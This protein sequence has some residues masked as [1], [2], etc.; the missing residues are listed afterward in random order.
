DD[1]WLA[2]RGLRTLAVRLAHHQQAALIV[3]KWLEGRREVSRV[4]YPALASCPGH[5]IWRRDFS[6]ANG[7][8]SVVLKPAS[9]EG[10][11]AMLDGM[12]LFRMGFSWGGFESLII[13][14]DPR[15]ART[16]TS[17]PDTG[18]CL[19]LHCG[20]E[21]TEDLLMDLDAGLARLSAAR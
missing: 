14:F 8:L 21:N 9:R 11:A 16:A 12:R 13:P 4:L 1:C 3:A 18:P 5:D 2:L 6:G 17:W 20:L 10:V 7:L 15:A 19:R